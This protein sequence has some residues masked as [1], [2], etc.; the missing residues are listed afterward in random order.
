MKDGRE[1]REHWESNPRQFVQVHAGPKNRG[2]APVDYQMVCVREDGSHATAA[3]FV[4]FQNGHPGE[5]NYNGTL[6]SALLAIL[7]D[8]QEGFQT[9]PWPSEQG[10]GALHH[11]RAALAAMDAR[12]ADRIK[13]DVMNKDKT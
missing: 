7:I 1:V 11:L 13:R 9:G 5:T 10:E 2:G 4:N 3:M 8:R 6:D 12:V